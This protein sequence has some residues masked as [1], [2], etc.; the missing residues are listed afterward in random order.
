MATLSVGSNQTYATI[1]AAVAA[2]SAGD[3]I[4]VQA[5]VYTND[6]LNITHDLTLT[7]IGGW[8]K[9]VTNQAQPPDGKAYITESGTVTISG[10]DISGVTV[11]DANGAGVRYQGGNLTLDNVFIHDNQEGLLG[12]ADLSG[13]ITITNSEFARNGLGGDGHTH[14]IYVGP[15][16]EFTLTNSY[17][18]D[19]V[20]GHEVKSRAQNN[21]ITNNRIFDNAGSASYSIDLPNGG[22]AT[23]QNNTIQQGA[24][25]QNPAILAYGEE[26]IPAGYGTGATVTGNTI[27][28]DQGSGYLL[29]NPGN[30]PVSLS[31]NTVF[32][33]TQIPSGS[34]VLAARPVLDL[35]PIQFLGAS[36]PPSPPPPAAPPP[37]PATPPSV[38]DPSP[39]PVLTPLEQYHADVLA[40]FKA[41]APLHVKLATMDKTLKILNTELTST[42]VLGI[43]KGDRWSN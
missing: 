33:L 12:A 32:G 37:P 13:S 7:A 1:A 18:H 30:H 41:W 19:T 23:I 40:D 28:N 29:L 11:P 27:V 43:I 25:S 20:V 10:F 14:G 8:V 35:A 42:T 17:I 9:L 3:T 5:G 16:S 34:T 6:W 15:V 38:P 39:T 21:V 31:D 24:N 22:N 4:T 26:G 36:P 2:S